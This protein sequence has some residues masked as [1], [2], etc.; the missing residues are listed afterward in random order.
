MRINSFMTKNEDDIMKV[1]DLNRFHCRLKHAEHEHISYC[2]SVGVL[3]LEEF[4]TEIL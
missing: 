3:K 2:S 1:G 4:P